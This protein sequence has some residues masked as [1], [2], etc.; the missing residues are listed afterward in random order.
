[1]GEKLLFNFCLTDRTGLPNCSASLKNHRH[2]QRPIR[3]PP[4][5]PRS[6]PESIAPTSAGHEWNNG[7]TR[8]SFLKRTG[9][10]TVAT[11][12]SWNLTV[13]NSQAATPGQ[14]AGSGCKQWGSLSLT[15][16][17]GRPFPVEIF[18]P[19]SAVPAGSPATD[20]LITNLALIKAAS[21]LSSRNDVTVEYGCRDGLSEVNP[22]RVENVTVTS[23]DAPVSTTQDGQ[24]GWIV[25]IYALHVTVTFYE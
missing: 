7:I 5:S 4:P 16:K 13:K 15:S 17:Y 10:A 11:F 2:E 6:Q 21:T 9:G 20:A 14:A 25:K 3:T 8:R 1:M 24:S 18:V 23:S 22:P 12:L 19:A